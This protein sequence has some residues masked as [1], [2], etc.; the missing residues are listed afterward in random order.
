VRV[1][2]FSYF[3]RIVRITRLVA[4][5]GSAFLSETCHTLGKLCLFTN[6]HG[7]DSSTGRLGAPEIQIFR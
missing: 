4:I 6:F 2:I 3:Q 7:C 5:A 1:S